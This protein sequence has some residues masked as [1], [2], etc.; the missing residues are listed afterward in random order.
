MSRQKEIKRA[1]RKAYNNLVKQG[2]RPTV[3][4]V[5]ELVTGDRNAI[6]QALKELRQ[7]YEVDKE[8]RSVR[9]PSNV[10][11][12]MEQV[13]LDLKG[14]IE[15]DCN[16][17]VAKASQ[18]LETCQESGRQVLEELEL[19]KLE[20]EALRSSYQLKKAELY[21]QNELIKNNEV[22]LAK[23]ATLN[24][25]QAKQ[26][27]ALQMSNKDMLAQV[28]AERSQTR[29]QLSH[30]LE[31]GR[32]LKD[33]KDALNSKY[34][35]LKYQHREYKMDAVETIK[36]LEERLTQQA[37]NHQSELT[38]AKISLNKI[39]AQIILEANEKVDSL[40]KTIL[41]QLS[42]I[43]K[44]NGE[45]LRLQTELK[46]QQQQGT[47]IGKVLS[48]LQTNLLAQ[49]KNNQELIKTIE[50]QKTYETQESS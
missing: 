12:A 9:L 18:E 38:E 7:E 37:I 21:S 48:L 13:Y 8:G 32:E 2:K 36:S 3:N 27:S 42:L 30:Q 24:E 6:S 28:E 47:E 50:L 17:K 46:T 19:T 43:E 35:G 20:L 41:E 4:A 34:D 22:K 16:L 26:V 1:C 45:K 15:E 11:R 49:E 14:G 5:S 29:H 33:E 39:Q 44:S 23:L 31:Q 10:T 40:N 25:Q